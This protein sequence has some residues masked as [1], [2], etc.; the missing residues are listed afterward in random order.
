M[1]VIAEQ[2]E[3]LIHPIM[4]DELKWAIKQIPNGKSH[5]KDSIPT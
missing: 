5:D 1:K 3:S 4:M 2:N